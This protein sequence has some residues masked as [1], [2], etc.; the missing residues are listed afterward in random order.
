[1]KLRNLFYLLLALP[2]VFAA[3]ET[4]GDDKTPEEPKVATLTVKTDAKTFDAEGGSAIIAYTLKDAPEGA[5]VSVTCEAN[6]V[7]DLDVTPSSVMF[8]VKANDSEEARETKVVISYE[9]QVFEVP[10]QQE[11]KE[12]VVAPAAPKFELT[13]NELMEFPYTKG[14]GTVYFTLENPVEGVNVEAKSN[15]DWLTIS[16][17][18]DG[19][20]D[21]FVAAN[22]GEEE[23]EA[24]ITA[25]YGK[26]LDPI[27]VTVK[28]A[29]YID[30]STVV[31]E[32]EVIECFA[33]CLNGGSQWDVIFIEKVENRGEIQTRISFA[34]EEANTQRITDGTYTV[35]NGGILLNTANL[36]GFSTYHS[37]SDATDIYAAEFVVSTDTV[38]KLITF[39]GTFSAGAVNV[40]L[41]YTGEVRGMDLGEAVSGAIEHT[42]WKSFQKNWQ[43]NKELLFTAISSDGSL[44]AVFDFY[45]YDDSKVLAEG[46][47]EVSPYYDGI[48]AHLRASSYFKYNGVEAQLESGSATVEHITGG[49]K[50]TYTV[51]DKNKR[52]FTGVIEGTLT[53]DNAVNPA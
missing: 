5:A 16:T 36:N 8:D 48:G 25:T 38:N 46:T 42:R 6:W 39:T 35:E 53:G 24:T 47:Y 17:I 41:N 4:P 27:V 37:N 2:L 28:Q 15:A 12:A 52:E 18:G 7:V 22:E 23:R 49:Y 30:P 19:T 43:E 13:S 31:N 10:V 44:T 1:M 20:I 3:C 26:Y 50:I 51:V 45:D 29:Y 9:E 33:T 21:F 14:S 40:Q 32:F 11:G 34:L